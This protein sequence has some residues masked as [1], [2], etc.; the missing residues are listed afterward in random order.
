M[1]YQ[2]ELTE[3]AKLDVQDA[4]LWYENQKS[5]LGDEFLLSVEAALSE[6]ERNPFLYQIKYIDVR[7]ALLR[8]F[9]YKVIY[10][11]EET[12]IG[13]LGVLHDRRDPSVWMARTEL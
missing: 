6:I 9:P 3:E 4:W 2:L 1:T 5:N 12:R 7:I 10:V 8:R 13:I 11:I